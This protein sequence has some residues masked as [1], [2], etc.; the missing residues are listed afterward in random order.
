M[1]LQQY[2]ERLGWNIS[3]LSRQA[4]IN[5]HTASKAVFGRNECSSRVALKIVEALS[6]ALNERVLVGDLEGLTIKE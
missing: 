1:T 5:R 2:C 4:D 3:E 6:R